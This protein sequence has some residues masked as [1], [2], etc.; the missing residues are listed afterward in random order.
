MLRRLFNVLAV[1]S[2]IFA[3]AVVAM[4]V[5]S[6]RVTDSVYAARGGVD[7]AVMTARDGC[8]FQWSRGRP[9]RE[10][11]TRYFSN[12]PADLGVGGNWRFWTGSSPHHLF[13][14]IR[15]GRAIR[16]TAGVGRMSVL[17]PYWLLA[18]VAAAASAGPLIMSF[19]LRRQSR[20]HAAGRCVRCGYDMR[21]TPNRCT[22]CGAPAHEKTADVAAVQGTSE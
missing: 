3:A 8:L 16:G 22:E 21:A 17:L 7:V 13:G 15:W 6:H 9:E 11:F 12:P 1:A 19:R 10:L 4:W 5:R 20:R 18:C 14:I 2:L